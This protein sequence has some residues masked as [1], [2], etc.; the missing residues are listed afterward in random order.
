MK[1]IAVITGATSGIG[2]ETA[3]KFLVEGYNVVGLSVDSE[4][5]V[6]KASAALAELGEFTYF[7]CNI[8]DNNS[9]KETVEK[10][11]EKY[12]QIDV[13]VNNAGIVGRSYGF[14]DD[15]TIEDAINVINVN[16]VGTMQL[17]YYAA[18]Y[19][20]EKKTG[21]IV[22]VGSLSGEIVNGVNI[23]YATSKAGV[24][25]ATQV[26]ARDLSP[27]GIRVVTIAPGCIK[28]ELL[29]DE[30]DEYCGSLS[31]KKRVIQPAEVAGAIYIMTMPEASC[32]NGSLVMADDGYCSFKM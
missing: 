29:P 13:L 25:M 7:P 26:M 24:H 19:M 21:V 2:F 4:E 3:K 30:F 32:I 6:N 1:K 23:G 28:T 18:K 20:A 22:N 15:N 9:V 12:G 31:F 8:A 17:S 5:K 10:I 14:L 16:L 11:I 27:L